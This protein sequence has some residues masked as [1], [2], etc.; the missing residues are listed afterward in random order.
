MKV[1]KNVGHDSNETPY[2]VSSTLNREF[3]RYWRLKLGMGCGTDYTITTLLDLDAMLCPPP[4]MEQRTNSDSSRERS[5]F[6]FLIILK[7]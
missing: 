1:M 3:R 5:T 6:L 7:K 4:R 2:K